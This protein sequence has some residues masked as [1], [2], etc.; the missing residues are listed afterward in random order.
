M[1]LPIITQHPSRYLILSGL[2][3]FTVKLNFIKADIICYV[4]IKAS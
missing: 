1:K 4:K 2:F 3:F